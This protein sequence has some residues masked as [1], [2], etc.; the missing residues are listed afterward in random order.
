MSRPPFL[1]AVAAA[2]VLAAASWSPVAARAGA[3]PLTCPAVGDAVVDVLVDSPAEGAEVSGGVEVAGVA[4]GPE[5]VFQVELFVGEARKDIAT[6]DPPVAEAAFTLAWDATAAPAGPATLVV[7]A[8]AGDPAT[9]SLVEGR[10]EVA[11]EVV[12]GA[13]PLPTWR[14]VPTAGDD[15]EGAPVLAGAVMAVPAVAALLY[16]AGRRRR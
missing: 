6:F 12:P 7:V 15:S 16:A 1:P 4:A 10:Q 8:C 3:Q 5:P 14:L 11:V 13:D 9:G 2:L